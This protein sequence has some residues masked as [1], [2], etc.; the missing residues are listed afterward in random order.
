MASLRRIPYTNPLPPGAEI[1]PGKEI[2]LIPP[3][4]E[5]IDRDDWPCGRFK[6]RCGNGKGPSWRP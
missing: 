6:E 1:I 4:V 5:V 3:G 2:G